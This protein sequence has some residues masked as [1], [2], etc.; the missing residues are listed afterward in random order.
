MEIISGKRNG[1]F[2]I[3]EP[4]HFAVSNNYLSVGGGNVQ[5]IFY[6]SADHPFV[7]EK[8]RPRIGPH[9]LVNEVVG[10]HLKRIFFSSS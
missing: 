6:L 4:F 2:K 9:K 5:K 1:K 10:Y 7:H 3:L 8:V